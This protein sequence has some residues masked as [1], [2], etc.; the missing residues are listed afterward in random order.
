MQFKH[1]PQLVASILLLVLAT[2]CLTGCAT[3]LSA[4]AQ[5]DRSL[6]QRVAG[7]PFPTAQQ[8]GIR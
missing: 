1:F 3:L 5:T 7:D 4:S 8:A 6:Q 2:G